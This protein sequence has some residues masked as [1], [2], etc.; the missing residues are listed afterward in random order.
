MK[1]ALFG[2]RTRAMASLG[3][4]MMLHDKP[5]LAGTLVGVVFAVVLSLQQLSILFGLL[6]KNTMLVDHAGADIW[7]APAGTELLQPGEPL[8]DAVLMRARTS[9]GVALAEPF[10]YANATIKRPDGGSE[11]VTL[12]GT[13]QPALLGG[14]WAM[15]AGHR[16]ALQR[17][18]TVIFEDA[19]REKLG[20]LNLD[21]RRE[22]NGRLVSV[23]GFTWGLLPFAPAYAFADIE[24]ARELAAIPD[25][26]HSFVLVRVRE[27]EDV[28]AVAERLAARVPE[29][30]VMTRAAFHDSIVARLLADQLGVSFGT[31]TAFGLLVGFA[32]VA[33]SM[34][35]SV[36]DHIREFGTLKAIGCT[37][38]D[39]TKLLLAQSLGYAVLG[40]LVGMALVTAMSNGIRTPQL[41]PI[42]QPQLYLIAP[43]VMVVLC[44][45]ASGL[46]LLRVRGLEPGMVFR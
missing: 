19:E 3:V 43:L 14:P 32:I 8:S 18:D 24:L 27:G 35:S 10:V 21:S 1:R 44:M 13:R 29:A 41:V 12:L 39:L 5:K 2:Y 28:D 7:I 25:D 16:S 20:G 9:E 23:G 11:P 17:P 31:S 6:D 22:L 26:A 33:L 4:D 40:S 34:F 38:W 36:L 37:N 30:K 15:V 46:A 45:F 42:I